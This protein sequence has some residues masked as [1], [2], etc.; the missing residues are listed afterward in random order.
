VN[1][2]YVCYGSN[3]RLSRFLCYLQGGTP[4]GST[5]PQA[6]ARDQSPP[7]QSRPLELAGTVYFA[8]SSSRWGGGGVAF[9]DRQE[10]G[11]AQCRG[12]WISDEQFSDVAAQERGR[13]PGDDLDLSD[14]IE[15]GHVILGPGWYDRIEYLGSLDG[16]PM[17]TVTS[18]RPLSAEA[19]NAPSADYLRTVTRGVM[20]T[21]GWT[22]AE[23]AGYLVQLPG[24]VGAWELDAIAHLVDAEG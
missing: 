22:A 10:A 1:V 6:G 21:N 18:P 17:V 2:W 3:L 12:Y 19:T 20:E 24:C 5:R 8:K 15:R 11:T 13:E 7:E 9:F 23:A 16:A 14:V 4:E